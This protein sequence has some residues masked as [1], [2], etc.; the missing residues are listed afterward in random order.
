MKLT[1]EDLNRLTLPEFVERVGWV[2]EHSPWVAKR[3]WV[4]RPFS[5]VDILHQTMVGVV[6]KADCQDQ[7]SLI[8]AHPDLGTRVKMSSVSQR[9][10]SGAGLDQLSQEE[11]EDFLE[12]NR[13]Y[14]QKFGF[15][16][17]MAVRGQTKE[18]IK[19]ALQ[20]RLSHSKEDESAHALQEI[21]KIS[22]FR[23]EDIF[24]S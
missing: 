4:D 1:V 12:L 3:A 7:L 8:R 18:T 11:Y 21:Y 24:H 5:S 2:F 22:R 19:F 6:E 17:I 13:S 16:F 15:P 14:M 9:E 23:L 20:E 10:Q